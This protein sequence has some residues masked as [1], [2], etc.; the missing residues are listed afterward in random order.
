MSVVSTISNNN[1]WY[2]VSADFD[3]YI[4]MQEHVN[5]KIYHFRL[6]ISGK[7]PKNGPKSPSEMQSDLVS[8][9]VTGLSSNMP[10]RYGISSPVGLLRRQNSPMIMIRVK[11]LDTSTDRFM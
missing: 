3:S 8:S 2:L 11:V 4:K 7:T 10:S 1:D 6:T 9:A 5:Y